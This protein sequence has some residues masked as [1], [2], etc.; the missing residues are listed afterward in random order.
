[1]LLFLL[2]LRMSMMHLYQDKFKR[3]YMHIFE[4]L[5]TFGRTVHKSNIFEAL[6]VRFRYLN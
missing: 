2:L 4:S 6:K 5:A 1:M 3:F